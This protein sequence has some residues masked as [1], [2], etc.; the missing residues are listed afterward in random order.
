MSI[1]HKFF[2]IYKEYQSGCLLAAWF[3]V[4]HYN[5]TPENKLYL[6]NSLHC[7]IFYAIIYEI[8]QILILIHDNWKY[9]SIICIRSYMIPAVLPE[10]QFVWQDCWKDW[11]LILEIGFLLFLIP[12]LIAPTYQ[13]S[14]K[15]QPS[16]RQG[17]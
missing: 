17:H 3:L 12:F 15:I 6:K 5:T 14:C 16:E 1:L 10:I 11:V 9:T 8:K 13:C 2:C 7:F 4:W